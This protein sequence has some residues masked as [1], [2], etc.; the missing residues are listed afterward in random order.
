MKQDGLSPPNLEI[1]LL[2][3]FFFELQEVLKLWAVLPTGCEAIQV[4]FNLLMQ[5]TPTAAGD[6]SLERPKGLDLLITHDCAIFLTELILPRFPIL[7]LLHHLNGLGSIKGLRIPTQERCHTF[8][9]FHFLSVRVLNVEGMVDSVKLGNPS[10]P[11]EWMQR[12]QLIYVNPMLLVSFM[13]SERINYLLIVQ[14]PARQAW[15]MRVLCFRCCS[16][17]S[18]SWLAF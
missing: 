18:W 7:A 9:A 15:K 10:V 2:K 11:R 3:L 14:L 16:V 5:K 12:G 4:S 17:W 8:A 1:L 13:R 6:L